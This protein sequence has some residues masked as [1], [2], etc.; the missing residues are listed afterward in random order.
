M[1]QQVLAAAP[2]PLVVAQQPMYHHV[3]APREPE[4]PEY[5]PYH[6][7]AFGCRYRL[8]TPNDYWDACLSEAQP[9]AMQPLQELWLSNEQRLHREALRRETEQQLTLRFEEMKA[10]VY[11][12]F[13]HP[14]KSNHAATVVV[15]PN[16]EQDGGLFYWLS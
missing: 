9:D 11:G 15:D 10:M 1:V 8:H 3:A 5:F 16:A 14:A 2:R 13:R 4:R 6:D 7:P 12:P